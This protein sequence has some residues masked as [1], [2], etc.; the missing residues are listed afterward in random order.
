MKTVIHVNQHHIK[1]NAKAPEGTEMLPVLSAKTYKDN[2]YGF[3]CI[4]KDDEGYE[5]GRF[6]YRPEKPLPCG[7][8]VWFETQ[9]GVEVVPHLTQETVD[10]GP[11]V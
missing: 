8:K 4:I 9:L 6:M 10:T 3:T 2:R 7:A 5:V 11:R 1:I